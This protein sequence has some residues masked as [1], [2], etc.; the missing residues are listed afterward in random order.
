[1]IKETG[2]FMREIVPYDRCVGCG[3]CKN[4]CPSQCISMRAQEGGFL[5]PVIDA[6][7]CIDC[8]RCQ[9]VCPALH[10]DTYA[11]APLPQAFAAHQRREEALDCCS[12]GGMFQLLA[13]NTLGRGGVVFGAA[14]DESFQVAH[15]AAHSWEEASDF[16][17]SKYVQSAIGDT[18]REAQAALEAGRPVLFTG[19]PCQISGLKRFLGRD[20]PNLLCQD[21]VCHSVPSPRVWADYLKGHVEKQGAGIKSVT[22]RKKEPD[23]EGYHFQIE[24]ENGAVFDCPGAQ[25]PY[26]KAFLNGLI[27]RPACHTC[28][29]K[30]LHRDSDITLADFW[31]VRQVCPAA[32]HAKGTS[33]V[34]V[35]TAKGMDAF[36]SVWKE[37]S[38]QEVDPVAAVQYN[39]AAVTPSGRSDRCEWFWARYTGENLEALMD[40]CLKPTMQA[41]LKQKVRQSAVAR[42]VKKAKGHF[43]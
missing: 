10:H 17:C 21:I 38:A 27:S 31:G 8:G 14:F 39:P 1:M 40:E 33:L 35:H 4:G 11:G 26:M 16:Q 20:D 32:F 28:P 43:R 2:E 15:R 5:Y 13:Q 34:L 30:G 7:R 3:A 42:I 6:E 9:A 12:S 22:F 24:F 18:Y 36:N 25:S 41:R 37:I 19:T 23:W 29:F